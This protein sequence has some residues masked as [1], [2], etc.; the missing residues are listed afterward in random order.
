[1][2]ILPMDSNGMEKRGKDFIKFLG[3][4]GARFVVSRQ[5]RASGGLWL[6]LG[7]EKILVDPGPG[8]LVRCLSSRPKLDPFVLSGVI[9]THRHLD[10]SN[11]VNIIIE[12]MTDGGRNRKGFLY[13]PRDVF[14]PP[15]SVVQTYVRAFLEK[16]DYLQEGKTIQHPS[17][18][19][20]TPVR[21]NHPVETYGL[22]FFLP[23]GT[24]SL[25][26][27]TRFF[28][29][30]IDHYRNSDILIINVVLFHEYNDE[31][32]F[33]LHLRQAA[34]IIKN[35]EPKVAV[36]THFGITML[37]KKPYLLAQDLQEQLG[38]RVIAA[39]DGMTLALKELI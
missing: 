31:R 16:I 34:E 9:L 23:Y 27:D 33:H 36:L 17:F 29:G 14:A 25:I 2:V 19:L 15:D 10:H 11:D 5:L 35:I 26:S 38:I 4:A 21:H 20:K 7:E 18:T 39:S 32:I 6:S 13:A 37:R 30:L 28:P 1:M 12:A 22:K 8:S 3:T 24:V